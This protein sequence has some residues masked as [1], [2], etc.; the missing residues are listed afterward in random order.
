MSNDKRLAVVWPPMTD[1]NQ[2]DVADFAARASWFT[3]HLFDEILLPVVGHHA[4]LVMPEYVS[5]AAMA[6]LDRVKLVESEVALQAALSCSTTFLVWQEDVSLSGFN[7][8]RANRF[9]GSIAVK[10]FKP[11]EGVEQST[12]YYVGSRSKNI[13][14]AY[15]WVCLTYWIY[16]DRQDADVLEP[17]K[18]K[19]AQLKHEASRFRRIAIFGTGPSLAEALAHD[20]SDAFNIVCNTIVKNRKFC[21]LLH[22]NL[23][24]ASDAHFHFS[25]HKYSAALLNDIA[26]QLK[27]NRASFFTFDKFATFL[28]YRIPEL[29]PMIFGIPAGREEYGYD[30]D[31]DY[32]VQA[33]DSVLNMFLLPLASYFGDEITLN[34]FTGRSPS[35]NYFW[36]HSELHQYGDRMADVRAAHPAFF[37][38][39]DYGGYADNVDREISLRVNFARSNG[40]RLSSSTKS[41]YSALEESHA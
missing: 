38:N 9:R 36:S 1:N 25:Y 30:F 22:L 13:Q 2:S 6:D 8:P 37:A 31:K 11:A 18:I 10:G 32:R 3:G 12:Y 29:A 28:K 15:Y 33:G 26:W 41:F 14:D 24:V 19:L 16:A 35:D 5:V 34:G 21:D 20:H 40:K 7:S 39:R 4:K 17:S 27:N 23:I